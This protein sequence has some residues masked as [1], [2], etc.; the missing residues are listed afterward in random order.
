[1]EW[2]FFVVAVASVL[3]TFNAIRP[4]P[5]SIVS[6]PSFFGGWLA[7]ELAI[8]RLVIQGAILVAFPLLGGFDGWQGTAAVACM[9][10][11]VAGTFYLIWVAKGTGDVAEEALRRG[12]GEDYLDRID[13]DLAARFDPTIPWRR[14]LVP[15]RMGLP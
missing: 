6:L 13:P 4:F 8:H 7:T 2:A 12:L 9:A 5:W 3:T 1:M 11:S 15:F 10:A 14:L